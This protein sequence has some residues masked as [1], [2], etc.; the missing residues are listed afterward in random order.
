MSAGEIKAGRAFV[1]ITAKDKTKAGIADSLGSLKGLAGSLTSVAGMVSSAI[2]GISSSAIALTVKNFADAGSELNDMSLRTG[3]AATKLDQFRFAAGQTGATLQD[4]EA[5]LRN[6]AKKGMNVKEF[7]ALGQQI[8]SIPDPAERA[9]AAMETFGK[10]GT[11]LIPMFADLRSSM[12]AYQAL[13]PVLTEEDIARADKLGDSIAALGEA[14]RRFKLQVGKQEGTQQIADFLTGF[15]VSLSDF[16]GRSIGFEETMRMGREANNAAAA[17]SAAANRAQMEAAAEEEAGKAA[18]ESAKRQEAIQRSITKGIE[19]RQRLIQ[20]TETEHERFLRKE[21]E[22]VVAIANVH[23]AMLLGFSDGSEMGGLHTALGRLRQAEQKRIDDS[24][25]SKQTKLPKQA[26]AEIT[27]GSR[28]TFS[29]AG[30]GMLGFG[31]DILVRDPE[32]KV[33]TK[34]LIGIQKVLDER[35]FVAKFG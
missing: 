32:N 16:S 14:W 5:A 1:E 31:S 4:V 8:A 29:A 7:E 33:H 24:L 3:I 19:E 23:R 12:A 10:S 11:R 2:A 20:E 13:G 15:V 25:K 26:Q 22:I 17:G 18:E 35:L 6:M 34:Q 9:A 30:A 27:T 21:R 28:G